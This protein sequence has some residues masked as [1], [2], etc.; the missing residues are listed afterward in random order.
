MESGSATPRCRFPRKAKGYFFF[1]STLGCGGEF[2][3]GPYVFGSEPFGQLDPPVL[4][5]LGNEHN[6]FDLHRR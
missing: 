6:G 5:R 4:D 3:I 1:S 2:G